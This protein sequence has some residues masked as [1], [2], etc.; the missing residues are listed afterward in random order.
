MLELVLTRTMET[1]YH[2]TLL[3]LSVAYVEDLDIIF[4]N[5]LSKSRKRYSNVLNMLKV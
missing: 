4:E 3:V 5:G 2:Y 1:M